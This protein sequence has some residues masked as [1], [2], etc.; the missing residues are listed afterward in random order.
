V[1]KNRAD[2]LASCDV[3]FGTKLPF[4]ALQ[5]YV[6]YWGYSG[7]NAD[8]A[9]GPLMTQTGPSARFRTIQTAIKDWPGPVVAD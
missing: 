9:F 5:H 3:A 6:G 4:A 1:N 7:L 8:V 2:F